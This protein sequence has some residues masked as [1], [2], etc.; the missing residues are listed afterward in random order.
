M[1][2]SVHRRDFAILVGDDWVVWARP[3]DVFD[4]SEPTLVR[5]ER[6]DADRKHLRVALGELTFE[7]RHCTELS[8]ADGGE[9]GGMREEHASVTSKKLMKVDRSCGRFRLE[10]RSFVAQLN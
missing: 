7:S 1:D 3:G 9:I 5:I 4:V 10:V 8:R 6:I 2:H